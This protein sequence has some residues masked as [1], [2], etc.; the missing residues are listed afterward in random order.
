MRTVIVDINWRAC[1]WWTYV[2][3]MRKVCWRDY[4]D[5][6]IKLCRVG[7]I[8]SPFTVKLWFSFFLNFFCVCHA[9]AED[10]QLFINNL[11][12][13]MGPLF[14]CCKA[15]LMQALSLSILKWRFRC[16]LLHCRQMGH[17]ACSRTSL[18]ATILGA[19]TTSSGISKGTSTPSTVPTW[20]ASSTYCTSATTSVFLMCLPN[21]GIGQLGLRKSHRSA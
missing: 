9:Y 10:T 20:K 15:S 14:S 8:L 2:A 12:V 17:I 3:M 1:L 13:I 7:L 6:T 11:G 21:Y 19:S 16:L 4:L 5:A 18:S